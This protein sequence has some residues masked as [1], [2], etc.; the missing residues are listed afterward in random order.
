MNELLV[1]DEVIVIPSS[2]GSITTNCVQYLMKIEQTLPE[3]PEKSY[4]NLTKVLAA[5]RNAP[6]RDSTSKPSLTKTFLLKKRT[7]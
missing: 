7:H 5:R 1:N 3:L 4:H 6:P 2:L